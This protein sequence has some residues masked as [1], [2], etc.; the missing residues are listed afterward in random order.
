MRLGKMFFGAEAL[1]GGGEDVAI[2]S[3]IG[4]GISRTSVE[5]CR[6]MARLFANLAN[7]GGLSPITIASLVSW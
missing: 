5:R 1:T 6:S 4:G 3:A 7:A 2:E